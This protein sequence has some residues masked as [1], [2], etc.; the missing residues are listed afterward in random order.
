MPAAIALDVL[1]VPSCLGQRFCFRVAWSSISPYLVLVGDLL[2]CQVG[3]GHLV[4][5]GLSDL[6][7]RSFAGFTSVK[8]VAKRLVVN[9]NEAGGKIEL[10]KREEHLG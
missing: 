10:M 6:M 3:D 8:K 9:L 1:V 4:V 5:G 7:L 2:V